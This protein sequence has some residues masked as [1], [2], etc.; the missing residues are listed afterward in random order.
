MSA[1]ADHA[2]NEIRALI[3][4]GEFAPGER[5]LE[6][7]LVEKLEVS[8]TPV[9]EAIRRLSTEGLI[10]YEPRCGA[11]MPTFDAQEIE[12]LYELSVTI[13]SLAAGLAAKRATPEHIDILE[14]ILLDLEGIVRSKK[15]DMLERYAEQDLRFHNQIILCTN[16][17]RLGTV[18]RQLVDSRTLTAIFSHFSPKQFE[19]SCQQHREIFEAVRAGDESWASAAMRNHILTGKHQLDN[20]KAI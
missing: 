7:T 4:S 1:S 11:R 13:E 15:G 12:D 5:L 19:R 8:R 14:A 3:Q 9:R 20:I 16:N 6:R 17:A 18:L 2:Y 10:I